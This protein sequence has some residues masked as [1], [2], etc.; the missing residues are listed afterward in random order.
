L[1]SSLSIHGDAVTKTTD[2]CDAFPE[3]V[4]VCAPALRSYGARS[5]FDGP[6]TTLKVHEDNLLVRKALEQP[7]LGRVLV[8]DG[9]GSM[10]RALVG[11]NLARMALNHGW[12]GIVVYGCIRDSAEIRGIEIGIVALDTHPLKSEKRGRGFVDEAVTFLGVTFVPGQHV[13]VDE[14]GVVVTERHVIVPS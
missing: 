8:V 9:G 5:T 7:G 12:A 3:L 1:F 6:I 13:W 10:R 4:H 2:L 11:D 14:D